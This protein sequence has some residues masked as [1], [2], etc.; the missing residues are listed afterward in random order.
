MLLSLFREICCSVAFFKY[1]VCP[2]WKMWSSVEKSDQFKY[3]P[4]RNI[5][6]DHEYLTRCCNIVWFRR[7]LGFLEPPPPLTSLWGCTGISCSLSEGVDWIS[8]FFL[9]DPFPA[10]GTNLW[11]DTAGVPL[12]SPSTSCSTVCWLFLRCEA[13][14]NQSQRGKGQAPFL[15]KNTFQF[16]VAK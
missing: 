4:F 10:A 5:C 6:L 13:A 8:V 7:D 16:H 14:V 15:I 11:N 1:R 3:D 12:F 2:H 9:R